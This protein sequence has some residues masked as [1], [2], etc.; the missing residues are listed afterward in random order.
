MI[1]TGYKVAIYGLEETLRIVKCAVDD[2]ECVSWQKAKKDLRSRYA[3][4]A[5]SLRYLSEKTYFQREDGAP[6]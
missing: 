4:L 6:F 2:P 1:K 5:A 3:T